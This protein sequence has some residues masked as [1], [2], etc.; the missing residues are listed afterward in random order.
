MGFL[1]D[2]TSINSYA[3]LPITVVSLLRRRKVFKHAY[4]E[5]THL[6]NKHKPQ[7]EGNPVLLER[8]NNK[9]R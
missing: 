5:A 7:L 6:F 1:M 3:K 2:A 8:P 4:I 9:L